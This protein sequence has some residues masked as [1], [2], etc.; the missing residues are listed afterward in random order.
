MN[1]KD[2]GFYDN[3]EGCLLIG[4]LKDCPDDCPI[5]ALWNE[6]Y[7]STMYIV[8]YLMK[9]QN[10]IDTLRKEVAELKDGENCPHCD[11]VGWYG[12][13]APNGEAGQE[14]CEWCDTNPNSKFNRQ[15]FK[16]V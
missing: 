4:L 9:Q 1:P 11:N 8:N 13:T 2:C 15:R 14:Q 6:W 7:R 12:V 16:T 10:E 3:S 5:V